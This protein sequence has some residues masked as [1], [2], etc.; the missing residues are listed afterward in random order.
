[1]SLGGDTDAGFAESRINKL[2]EELIDADVCITVAAGN[3]ASSPVIPPANCPSVITVGGYGDENQFSNDNFEL[4]HSNFGT[5]IDGLVKPEIIAPAMFVA[6]P[7]LP[8]TE[9]YEK[10]KSFRFWRTRRIM[11]FGFC[12]MN[13]GK[14]PVYPI[15]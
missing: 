12:S 15:L 14:K 2:A 7:I 6:A 3:S 4:Y 10:P 1:M 8:E 13:T 11:L 5:T 9:D